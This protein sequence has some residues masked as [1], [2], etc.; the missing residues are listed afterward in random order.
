MARAIVDMCIGLCRA[1]YRHLALPVGVLT[2]TTQA[3][4]TAAHVAGY[5]G[6][7]GRMSPEWLAGSTG[8]GRR[9]DVRAYRGT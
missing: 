1:R 3:N 6:T 7:S 2:S 9:S 5:A 4:G 8:M